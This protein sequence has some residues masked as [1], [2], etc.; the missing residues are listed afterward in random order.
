[1]LLIYGN[2]DAIAGLPE[3]EQQAIYDDVDR[4]LGELRASGEL[5]AGDGLAPVSTARTVRMRD[6]VVV[7][8]DGP[9]AE[10]KE[11]FGGYV[12]VDVE[13]VERAVEIAAG[14]PGLENSALEVRAV[15]GSAEA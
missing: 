13:S 5:V 9:F 1:M 11:Q 2:P 4:V 6:G 10:T 3:A 8:T 7:A 15:V 12:M 14:W